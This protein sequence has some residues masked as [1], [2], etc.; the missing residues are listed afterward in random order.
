VL[1]FFRQDPNGRTRI[2]SIDLIGYNER[3]IIT[4]L[5]ASDPGWSPLIP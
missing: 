3:E 5:D 4:P 2:Y 1:A